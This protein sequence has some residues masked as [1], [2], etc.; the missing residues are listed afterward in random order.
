MQTCATTLEIIVAVLR[1]LGVSLSQDSAILLL[2]IYP[3][4]AKSYYKIICSS[5]FIAAL[6]VTARTYKQPRDPSMEEWIKK[7]WYIFTLQYY[8]EVKSM[9][10]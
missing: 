8:S 2:G 10:S 5:M 6:F 7:M 3:K 4:D 1:K 9:T